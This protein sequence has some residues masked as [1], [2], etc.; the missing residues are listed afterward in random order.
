MPEVPQNE[1]IS[2]NSYLD[3]LNRNMSGLKGRIVG[4]VSGVQLYEGRTYLFFSIKDKSTEAVLKCFM[5]KRSYVVSGVELKDGMEIIIQGYPQ[6]YKPSG[7]LTFQTS[8]IEL[9][10]EGALKK[11]YDELKLKL[12]KEGLFDPERKRA[13]PD[14]PQ[15]I[16]LITSQSGAAIGDFLT[17]LGKFGFK[18]YH[19]DSRVEGQIAT[20]ELLASVATLKKK[21]IDVL[22]MIRGGGSLESFLPFNNEALIR[23][24]VSFPVPVLVGIGHERDVPLV[25]LA[26]DIR[27]STPTAAAG[28]LSAPWQQASSQVDA[29]KEKLMRAFHNTISSQETSINNSF[30]FMKD[31]LQSI[32]D[33]FNRME[34]VI[35]EGLLKIK[36]GVNDMEAKVANAPA[37]LKEKMQDLIESVESDLSESLEGAFLKMGH[38]IQSLS[39]RLNFGGTVRIF[40]MQLAQVLKGVESNA[41]ILTTRDPSNLLKLGY[42]IA[43][44]SGRVVKNISQIKDGDTFSLRLVDGTADSKVIK[45]NKK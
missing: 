29:H 17:N 11:A 41:A 39:S 42:T 19:I 22:V 4:E 3:S 33:Q 38:S 43:T 5:W 30:G 23:E 8:T 27:A 45:I 16:G 15:K 9:V 20:Q 14:Y 37:L 10:G 35:S 13:L 2:V 26:A 12:E 34:R 31:Q 24:I 6:V 18:V 32:F 44:L 25:S 21:D 1:P 36:V 7:S 28:A 40:G